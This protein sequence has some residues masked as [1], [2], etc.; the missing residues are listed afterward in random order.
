MVTTTRALPCRPHAGNVG[1]DGGLLK[2]FRRYDDDRSGSI[3]ANEMIMLV[4]FVWFVWATQ[5]KPADDRRI[6]KK[7][8]G[9]KTDLL[10]GS[11]AL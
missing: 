4:S 9:R 8:V 7:W 3:T 1:Y 11:E 2:V 10:V 5:P 6:K